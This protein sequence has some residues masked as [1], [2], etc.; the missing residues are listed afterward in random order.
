MRQ[1][2]ILCGGVGSRIYPLTK[3]MPKAMLTIKGKPFLYYQLKVLEQFNF[4]EVILCT[5]FLSNKISNFFKK[6]NLS[7]K[8]KFL[9]MGK[10]Y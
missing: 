2:V 9:K 6:K 1:I 5:G 8:L 3:H 4:K 10:S 7:L